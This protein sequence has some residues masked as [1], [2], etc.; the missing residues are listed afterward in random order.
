MRKPSI[1]SVFLHLFLGFIIYVQLKIP[2]KGLSCSVLVSI[3]ENYGLILRTPMFRTELRFWKESGAI[4][5][6]KMIGFL[7]ISIE[8]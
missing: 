4:S 5:P 6:R 7:V 1:F 8:I 2:N 3:P